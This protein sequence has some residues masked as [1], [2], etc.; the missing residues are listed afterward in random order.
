MGSGDHLDGA[1]QLP[2]PANAWLH[3]TADPAPV[4]DEKKT[5]LNMAPA[6]GSDYGECNVTFLFRSVMVL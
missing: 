2:L 6:S 1:A 5:P 3:T 4:L